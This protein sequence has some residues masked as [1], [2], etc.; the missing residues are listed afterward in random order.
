MG[1]SE[2][3]YKKGIPLN[4]HPKKWVPKASLIGCEVPHPPETGLSMVGLVKIL[5]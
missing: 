3:G 5:R 2:L 1:V 4:K